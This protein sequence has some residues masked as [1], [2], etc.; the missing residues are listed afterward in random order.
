MQPPKSW[1]R[2]PVRSFPSAALPWDLPCGGN[3]FLPVHPSFPPLLML[4]GRRRLW[5]LD[6][7][8]FDRGMRLWDTLRERK[9]HKNATIYLLFIQKGVNRET[10]EYIPYYQRDYRICPFD[11]V[12]P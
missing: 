11:S 1:P 12:H 8:H 6:S 9:F 5:L 7:H 3:D 2:R 10:R 4:S